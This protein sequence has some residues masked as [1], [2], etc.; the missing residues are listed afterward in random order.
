MSRIAHR[1]RTVDAQIQIE[2]SF[3]RLAPGT[4]PKKTFTRGHAWDHNGT[5]QERGKPVHLFQRRIDIPHIQSLGQGIRGLRQAFDRKWDQMRH[6]HFAIVSG[7]Q[8]A[9]LELGPCRFQ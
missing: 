2:R 5:G 8:F 7:R 6:R 9:L 1:P 3:L 4:F